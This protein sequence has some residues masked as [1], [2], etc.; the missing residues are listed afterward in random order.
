MPAEHDLD[1]DAMTEKERLAKRRYE[2]YFAFETQYQNPR[3][4][5]M[6]IK[7]GDKFSS[8]RP[9]A[10]HVETLTV[11]K[12][13]SNGDIVCMFYCPKGE[14]ETIAFQ[15]EDALHQDQD[16]NWQ[17]WDGESVVELVPLPPVVEDVVKIGNWFTAEPDRIA[18]FDT[19][20][21][22][23]AAGDMDTAILET[24]GKTTAGTVLAWNV[25]QDKLCDYATY[26]RND[27][28]AAIIEGLQARQVQFLPPIQ[29]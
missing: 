17:P 16:F 19:I 20:E 18:W 10:D 15:S 11:E 25:T 7:E 22:A 5:A 4:G 26:M 12:I 13:M 3:K 29:Y 24:A 8:A 21:E 27:L 1:P 28:K 6:T 2:A 23:A 14:N 9:G